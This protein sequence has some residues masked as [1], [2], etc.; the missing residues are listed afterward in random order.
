MLNRAWTTC[1]HGCDYSRAIPQS[2]RA[3]RARSAIETPVSAHV[4]KKGVGWV[5]HVLVPEVLLRYTLD[6]LRSDRV[7]SVLDLS[8]G[9]PLATRHELP[10]DVFRNGRSAV[11]AEQQAR[12]ELALGTLNLTCRWCDAHPG[13]LAQC[14]VQQV[15]KVGK[16]LR[17]EIDTP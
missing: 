7:D 8:G 13:P 10:P 2:S 16:V 6:L 11:E 4:G 5:T 14:K 15:V 1:L 12:L 3:P 9:H 17:N